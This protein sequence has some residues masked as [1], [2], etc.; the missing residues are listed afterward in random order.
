MAWQSVKGGGTLDETSRYTA[1]NAAQINLSAGS[2]ITADMSVKDS[3]ALLAKEPGMGWLAQLQND[4]ALNQKI[5][6]QSIEE[7]HR[8][9]DY[10]QQGLTPAAAVVVAIVVAFVTAGA[11]TAALGTTTAAAAGGTT[12]AVAGT[13]LATTTAVGVTTY[14]TTGIVLNAAVTTLASKAAV[15]LINNGGDL[16]KTLKELGSKDSLQQLALSMVTAGVLS[17]VGQFN[18]GSAEHPFILNDIKVGNGFLPNAGKNLVNGLARATLNSAITGTDLETNLRTEVIA[19]LLSAGSA[20]GAKW[21]GDQTIGSG[22]FINDAGKINEFGRAISHAIVGC[23][24]GAV[25]AS[26]SGS[27]TSAGS[28]CSAGALGAVVGELSAQLYGATDQSKTIAFASMMSGIAAAATGQGAQGV[29]IAA[30]TGANAAEN[31][32]L[33][34]TRPALLRLSEKERY[35]AAATGCAQGDNA[36]CTTRNELASLS[37]QRDQEL[38]QTCAG[39]NPDLCRTL[40]NEA[41]AMGNR[42]FVTESGFT[43]ANSSSQALAGL[44]TSTIG[45]PPDPRKGSFHD[46]AAR[47]TSEAALLA[48]AGVGVRSLS[49]AWVAV[50]TPGKVALGGGAAAGFDA[51]GQLYQ[52]ESYRVGQTLVAGTTGALA[53][54]FASTSVLIN[55]SLGGTV[56]AMN[57]FINNAIYGEDASMLYSFGLGFGFSG[58]GTVAGKASK[59]GAGYILPPRILTTP[60]NPPLPLRFENFWKPNPYPGYIDTTLDQTMS[61]IPAFVPADNKPTE[62]TKP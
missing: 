58:A 37:R 21:V 32:Y 4:P 24:S 36:A 56:G 38:A 7:A 6:W 20:Q 41:I 18:F 9:W 43:Y 34:H 28:G 13:T 44:N 54:P 39:G 57:T 47:S 12:T 17:E 31:N 53:G 16:G 10:Q 55:A 25:G 27:N 2:R 30:G 26:A 62:R 35:E 14:T 59:A 11:G 45:S 15:S 19:G 29:A 49:T 46:T 52:G 40:K 50:S 33:N 8:K 5:D 51:A 1:L 48:S 22:L 61:N 3:A 60:V 23:M 42:V